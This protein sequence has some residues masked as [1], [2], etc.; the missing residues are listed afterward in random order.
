[1]YKFVYLDDG[2]DCPKYVETN[3]NIILLYILYS[4]VYL[5]GPWT[6]VLLE[7]LTALS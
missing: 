7:K 3:L 1:V 2:V 4:V 6:R 5:L